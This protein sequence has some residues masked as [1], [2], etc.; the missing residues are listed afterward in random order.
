MTRFRIAMILAFLALPGLAQ[1]VPVVYQ[2]QTYDV[3]R[4]EVTSYDAVA[5]LLQSQVW[6]GNYSA[7]LEFAGLVNTQLGDGNFTGDYGPL[8]AYL[9]TADGW[10]ASTTWN[11]SANQVYGYSALTRYDRSSYAIAQLIPASVPEPGT[12]ALF[13]A[14]LLGVGLVRRRRATNA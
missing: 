12:L 6:W 10:L 11:S 9:S 13:S 2:G 7:A 14:A 1:A 5:S 8:F 3:T 4:T